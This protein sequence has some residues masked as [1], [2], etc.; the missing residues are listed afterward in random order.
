[1]LSCLCGNVCKSPLAIC[2]KGRAYCVPG[3][4]LSLYSPYMVNRDV[5]MIQTNKQIYDRNIKI[6]QS[7]QCDNSALLYLN[8][9]EYGVSMG[10]HGIV[11]IF[12]TVFLDSGANYFNPAHYACVAI[13]EYARNIKNSHKYI[14][15]CSRSN[16]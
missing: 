3:F 15:T 2:R 7:F 12:L 16:E 11:R 6:N 14:R 4:C 8:K 10:V 13:H 9:V 1:M 5:N